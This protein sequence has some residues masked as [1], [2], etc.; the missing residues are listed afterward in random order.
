MM[1]ARCIAGAATAPATAGLGASSLRVR[2]C[3]AE[4]RAQ[5]R[6]L[7]QAPEPVLEAR[8]RLLGRADAHGDD[9]AL[10]LPAVRERPEHHERGPARLALVPAQ[11]LGLHAL[12]TLREAVEPH[13]VFTGGPELRIEIDPEHEDG[14]Q[15]LR[16]AEVVP[17]ELVACSRRID[18]LRARARG[19]P[20]ERHV[21]ERSGE[22]APDELRARGRP[23]VEP[24]VVEDAA[25]EA[26]ALGARVAQIR[27]LETAGGEDTTRPGREERLET[28]REA[29]PAEIAG[30]EV[31][32]LD[33][34]RVETRLAEVDLG[35]T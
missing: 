31:G 20:R 18:P 22:P 34:Q 27:F 19:P 7:E 30:D 23:A 16:A 6:A 15:E 32:H 33:L 14:V 35:Q 29:Q 21:G 1:G 4:C 8:G 10:G 26:R 2:S 17:A 9:V 11:H 25:L 28:V 12:D 24:R 3:A 13:I 5:T